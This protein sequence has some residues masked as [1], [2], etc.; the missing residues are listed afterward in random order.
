MHITI[1]HLYLFL[2]FQ[3]RLLPQ[4]L[5][6]LSFPLTF[7]YQLHEPFFDL[8]WI[9]KGCGFL[10]HTRLV[11]S[12]GFVRVSRVFLIKFYISMSLLRSWWQ[13]CC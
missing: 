6:Q 2:P 9:L 5:F 10:V 12:A 8:L 3:S 4:L 11:R 13:A 1:I 7:A